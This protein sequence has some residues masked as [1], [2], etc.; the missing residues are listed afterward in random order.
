[1]EMERSVL[2]LVSDVQLCAFFHKKKKNPTFMK[3]LKDKKPSDD[4]FEEAFDLH[5]NSDD[6]ASLTKASELYEKARN[7]SPNDSGIGLRSFFFFLTLFLLS[8]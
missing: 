5:S 8:F 1:M 6:L 4:L 3:K 2:F 7:L